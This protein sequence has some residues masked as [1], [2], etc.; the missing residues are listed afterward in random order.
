MAWPDKTQFKAV[1]RLA[2][3]PEVHSA[4]KK[5]ESAN[6]GYGY[7][8]GLEK[9]TVANAKVEAATQ[10]AASHF[11]GDAGKALTHY[12]RWAR[13]GKA[14]MSPAGIAE[15]VAAGTVSNAKQIQFKKDYMD[16]E[17]PSPKRMTK[18]GRTKA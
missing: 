1:E 4:F 13:W 11:G 15:D 17:N 18:P 7:A 12:K 3:P 10:E 2:V 16:E 5:L 8:K 6:V 14:A 9:R